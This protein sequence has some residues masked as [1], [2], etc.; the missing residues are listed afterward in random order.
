MEGR[1]PR[2][3]LGDVIAAPRHTSPP[4]DQQPDGQHLC[5]LS[6]CPPRPRPIPSPPSGD[7]GKA[8]Q[9]SKKKG[10]KRENEGEGCRRPLRPF[11]AS[12][13]A[14]SDV[15]TVHTIAL[16]S[17]PSSS[18]VPVIL[19]PDLVR[20]L[21]SVRPSVFLFLVPRSPSCLLTAKPTTAAHYLTSSH[22][23]HG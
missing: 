20:S 2:P 18:A 21:S 14:P 19:R 23:R 7:K 9:K 13:S 15:F 8:E 22:H 6:S 16:S 3:L 5:C 4:I 1:P 12:P 17:L 10:R 11:L